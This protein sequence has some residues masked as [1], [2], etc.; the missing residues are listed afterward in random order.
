[1]PSVS[2]E[3]ETLD[4][5]G[6]LRVRREQD[7]A[8]PGLVK[9]Y[10]GHGAAFE[11]IPLAD[12]SLVLGR[13]EECSLR[14]EDGRMSRRHAEVA[15]H[16]GRWIVRDLGSRNGTFIDGQRIDG[17]ATPNDGAV[18]TLGS[19]VFLLTRDVRPLRG[20]GVTSEG[21]VVIG[22]RLR[23][24]WDTIRR[25]AAEAPVMHITGETGTGKEVAARLFHASSPRANKPF[26]AVNCATI[27][28]LLAERLLFGARKGAY[29][30]ADADADGYLVAADG[31][32]VF[33]DEVAELPLEVQAKLLRAI[34]SHEVVPLGAAKPRKVELA[35]CSATHVDLRARVGE[36]RFREDLYFRLARPAVALP[37]LRER[38]EELPFIIDA[39]LH[40]MNPPRTAHLSLIVEALLRPWPGNLRELMQ[41]VTAAARSP[42]L[43]D[44]LND[45]ERTDPMEPPRVEARHL[46]ERAGLPFAAAPSAAAQPVTPPPTA[47]GPAAPDR[48][49]IVAALERSGGNVSGAARA[50]GVHRTQL[51]RWLSRFSLDPRDFGAP[52]VGDD[53][54]DGE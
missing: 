9:V 38:R 53:P 31:G 27:P 37:P 21:N 50:L 6:D 47:G 24:V 28:P 26:I 10:A 33:L 2:T 22:P 14:L 54:E 29:S 51:R 25:L 35:I 13:G 12:E 15:R 18:L 19:T 8:E 32:T 39:A 49:A 7:G 41:E 11:P 45:H 34:E 1:L 16:A 30:G 44:R 23:P 20:P 52:N 36:K 5:S 3:L 43:V 42:D 17:N 40:R 46:A 4:Q 48:D